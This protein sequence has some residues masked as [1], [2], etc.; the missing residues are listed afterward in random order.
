V[1]NSEVEPGC[2]PK[3]DHLI[4]EDHKPVESIYIEKSYRLLTCPLYASWSGPGPGR[5]FLVLANVGYFPQNKNPALV[6]DCLL[7]LD[8]TLPKDLHA[9]Q[10]HSYYQWD[11]GKPPDVIIEIVSNTTDGEDSS[12]MD[13]Y[14]RQAIPY[15][16]IYDPDHY[17]SPET[18]R[19]FVL[20]AGT[21]Q[22]TDPGPWPN[23]GLGLRLWQG[24]FERVTDTWLR[25]CD[26]NGVIIP[27][28]EERANQARDRACREQDR[29]NREKELADQAEELAN[30]EQERAD[31][32]EAR[33]C[34]LEAELRRLRGETP[35]EA[36]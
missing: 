11:R 30:R 8:V 32:A 24:P 25:W 22:P 28:G 1:P 10:G 33:R 26:A 36:R 27:T 35:P 5:P 21:Y 18:L 20:V 13:L 4:T 19:C 16:V 15:Y 17:L 6:P 14:A 2:E 23:I 34:E 12:K 3:Y 7:S 9:K 31:R 29:F